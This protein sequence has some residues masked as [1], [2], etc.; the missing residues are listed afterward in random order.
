MGHECLDDGAGLVSRQTYGCVVDRFK[1]SVTSFDTFF[2]QSLQ[3]AI[4]FNGIDHQGHYCSIR[5]DDEILTQPA[6]ET[7]AGYTKSPVLIGET[8]VDKIITRLRH[9][10][11]HALLTSILDLFFD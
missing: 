1:K 11:R 8:I 10:P 3:V 9:S 2:F 7:E 5:R 4:A 6:F